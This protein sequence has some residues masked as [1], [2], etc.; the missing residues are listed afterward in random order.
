MVW[1]AW[2]SNLNEVWTFINYQLLSVYRAYIWKNIYLANQAIYNNSICNTLLFMCN[3]EL[4]FGKLRKKRVNKI[5]NVIYIGYI[6][7]CNLALISL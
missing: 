1:I 4:S 7:D 5:L 2:I 6:Y 3:T